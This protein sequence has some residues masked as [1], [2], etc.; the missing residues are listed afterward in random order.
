MR[1]DTVS[2]F[3]PDVDEVAAQA[4]PSQSF[5]RRAWF[6][7]ALDAFGLSRPR[8]LLGLRPDGRCAIA[9]PIARWRP[10]SL[11]L[12]AVPG[13]YWPMRSFPV[14]ADLGA[15]EM[16]DFLSAPA[17]RRALG[18]AC[19]IGPVADDDP[20][21]H[22]L[23]ECA[24][25]SGWV[26]MSR[27]LGHA[28]VLDFDRVQQAGKWPRGSTLQRNRY[29][30]KQLAACGALEWRYVS[31]DDWSRATFDDL[32]EIEA[33]SWVGTR[34]ERTDPKF[35]GAYRRFWE[36]LALDAGLRGMMW[37]AILYVG[38]RP[39][40]F[41][42]D[43]NCQSTKYII[44]NSYDPEFAKHS[45]GRLLYY[46]NLCLAREQLEIRRVNWGAGDGGYKSATG[47]E[48]GPQYLDLLLCRNFPGSDMATKLFERS[49]S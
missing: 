10:F 47:A 27:R 7:A 11:G 30:E 24:P 6:Q 15:D 8:V 1:V 42:F 32:A 41:S 14:G 34:T 45:P 3:P 23:K 4:H 9:M 5:L 40:A 22:R 28:F 16:C 21:L 39:V 36:L 29:L 49:G 20:A 31:N 38:G 18:I 48:A 35:S 43:L 2:G 33:K 13:S 44:A 25:R 19:R 37:A 26:L 46:R 12:Q 17:T